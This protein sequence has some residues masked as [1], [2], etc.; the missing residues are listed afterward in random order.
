[1]ASKTASLALYRHLLR[2]GG[3]I[4]NYNFS[5]HARRRITEGFKQHQAAVPEVA[6]VQYDFGL[7]QLVLVKRQAV[8]GALYPHDISVMT[9]LAESHRKSSV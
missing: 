6:A 7:Q 5:A 8:I 2:H 9:T 4:T 3:K 1:M